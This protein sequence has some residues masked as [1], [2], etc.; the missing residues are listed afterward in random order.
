MFR[1]PS[2]G[3]QLVKG[4]SCVRGSLPLVMNKC[5]RPQAQA[6]KSAQLKPNTSWRMSDLR[7]IF[8]YEVER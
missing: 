3:Q 5:K 8:C 4:E 2:K 1:K 7:T 6:L